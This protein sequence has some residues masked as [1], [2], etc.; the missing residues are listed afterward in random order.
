MTDSQTKRVNGVE[1]D[2]WA[3]TAFNPA[4]AL[5]LFLPIAQ[6]G[7]RLFDHWLAMNTEIIRFSRSRIS[8]NLEIG[9]AAAKLGSY[10]EAVA[11]QTDYINSLATD[12][13]AE[14]RKL[15]EFGMDTL[16]ETLSHTAQTTNGATAAV[17]ATPETTAQ[18]Q[19]AAIDAP[20]KTARTNGHAAPSPQSKN[21]A[22]RRRFPRINVDR[23]VR[24]ERQAQN[25]N[26][27]PARLL[28]LS[29][30][31]AAIKVRMAVEEGEEIRM[32]GLSDEPF[33]GHVV[34]ARDGVVRMRF[35]PDETTHARVA[36][37]VSPFAA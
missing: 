9:S 13:S 6:I 34:Q 11:W 29:Q 20:P 15:G 8:R 7:A 32:L 37:L 31:G 24:L 23:P 33:L 10:P 19:P 36:K 28:N 27:V 25:G 21:E 30:G 5:T 1:N 16:K 35:R 14:L 2:F 22:E 12:Y 3:T 4:T 18:Y 26:A 17:Q